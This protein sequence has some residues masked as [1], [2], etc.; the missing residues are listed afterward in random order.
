MQAFQSA[1]VRSFHYD[2]ITEYWDNFKQY[3]VLGLKIYLCERSLKYT[4]C[5]NIKYKIYDIN[6]K[7]QIMY[8]NTKLSTTTILT[9]FTRATSVNLIDGIS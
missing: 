8:D 4:D 9:E 2:W 3:N 6:R 5:H 1:K 7:T